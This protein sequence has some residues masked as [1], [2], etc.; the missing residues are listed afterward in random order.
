MFIYIYSFYEANVCYDK[1]NINA[2]N[3]I[4]SKV[5]PLYFILL[6]IFMIKSVHELVT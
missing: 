1:L 5:K 4:C 3:H 6:Q 2:W